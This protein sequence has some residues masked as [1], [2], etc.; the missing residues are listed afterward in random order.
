MFR[1]YLVFFDI[2]F[3]ILVRYYYLLYD[4]VCNVNVYLFFV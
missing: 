4:Y 2:G 1:L 3:F